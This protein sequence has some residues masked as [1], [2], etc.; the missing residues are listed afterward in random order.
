MGTRGAGL[1]RLLEGQL[2]NMVF[3]GVGWSFF[4]LPSYLATGWNEEY[5]SKR[6]A[7]VFPIVL[8]AVMILLCIEALIRIRGIV[9]P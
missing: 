6:S 7:L 4:A 5:L 9:Y 2:P 3:F 1:A 8:S